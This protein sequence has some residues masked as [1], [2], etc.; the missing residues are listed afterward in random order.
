MTE[1]RRRVRFGEENETYLGLIAGDAWR[2]I[3][4]IYEYEYY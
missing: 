2:V 4:A 1:S 3:V